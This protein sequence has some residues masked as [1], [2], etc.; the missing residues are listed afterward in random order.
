MLVTAD[1]DFAETSGANS[2]G[3]KLA[4]FEAASEEGQHRG[5]PEEQR[6]QTGGLELGFKDNGKS[7]VGTRGL[8]GSSGPQEQ[9]KQGRIQ[10]LAWEE[11]VDELLTEFTVLALVGS[12]QLC[13]NYH[14]ALNMYA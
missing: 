8:E 3:F 13:D 14:S 9:R 12:T 10:T 2:S 6:P 11:Y 1:V 4:P 7:R 5:G